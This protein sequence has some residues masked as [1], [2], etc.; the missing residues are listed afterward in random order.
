MLALSDN[1]IVNLSGKPTWYTICSE[2]PNLPRLPKPVHYKQ[3]QRLENLLAQAL[4]YLKQHTFKLSSTQQQVT[5]NSLTLSSASSLQERQGQTATVK[6]RSP[7]K[8]Q[9][10]Q[11]ATRFGSLSKVPKILDVLSQAAQLELDTDASGKASDD[12][13]KLARLSMVVKVLRDATVEEP[14]PDESL[15]IEKKQSRLSSI[16]QVLQDAVT[17]DLLPPETPDTVA[18]L[19]PPYDDNDTSLST[20]DRRNRERSTTPATPSEKVQD[21]DYGKS[22]TFIPDLRESL[23]A[24][25]RKVTVYSFIK[26]IENLTNMAGVT[27]VISESEKDSGSELPQEEAQ[28]GEEVSAD[29]TNLLLSEKEVCCKLFGDQGGAGEVEMGDSE[30]VDLTNSS[31]LCI[32]EDKQQGQSREMYGNNC[33]SLHSDCNHHSTEVGLQDGTDVPG[34]SQVEMAVVPHYK[35]QSH[36]RAVY[37]KND[38]VHSDCSHHSEVSLQDKTDSPDIPQVEI[39]VTPHFTTVYPLES[40]LPKRSNRPTLLT[41]PDGDL[42]KK[43]SRFRSRSVGSLEDLESDEE[44][45]APQ[46]PLT[47]SPTSTPIPPTSEQS[48]ALSFGF[49]DFRS[50]TLT[51]VCE[52]GYDETEMSSLDVGARNSCTLPAFSNEASLS[53]PG[54]TK[55]SREE[56]LSS[57]KRSSWKKNPSLTKWKSF[58]DILGSLKS[59]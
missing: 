49:E 54:H 1:E 50:A 26:D 12:N 55:H 59:K 3:K 44:C 30:A 24:N 58:D 25:R 9:R 29:T 42:K 36:P 2:D 27:G 21:E 53:L 22:F 41:L 18:C 10:Q 7:S 37:S 14:Q 32:S 31:Q 16:L 19:Q 13:S 5:E 20:L 6:R 15:Q 51:P 45:D 48:G 40:S 56:T 52:E 8:R 4:S 11:K 46:S 33:S 38:N 23:H 43:Q 57:K 28:L 39:T 34:V 47:P 17:T 35:Q